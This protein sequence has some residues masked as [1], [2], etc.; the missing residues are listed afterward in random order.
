[1]VRVHQVY[2]NI[3]QYSENQKASISFS[4]FPGIGPARFQLLISY[5]GNAQNAWEAPDKTLAQVGFPSQLLNSFLFFRKT[6]NREEYFNKLKKQHII[7]V[8]FGD[9][10]YPSGLAQ[11]SDPPI[12]LYVNVKKGTEKIDL[13]K[14]IGVVGTRQV[15][16]YGRSVTESL[17]KAL[18][19]YGFTI[20]SGMALGVDAIAHCS[21]LENGGKTIAVLGCGVDIVAPSS[22]RNIYDSILSTG[23]GAIISEMPLGHMPSKGLFP[24]RNRIISGLSLGV[25]V[26][27]GAEDSGALITA[28]FAAD[29]G[30][31][32]FAVPG[33]I[34]SVFSKGPSKLLKNGATLVETAEDVLDALG[35]TPVYKSKI[36]KI[37]QNTIEQALL[38]LLGMQPMDIDE[39]VK[40]TQIPMAQ[41][42]TTLTVLELRGI[43]KAVGNRI[44]EM[45]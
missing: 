28:K 11:I 15:T 43:I 30:R 13:S 22:N 21:A 12:V 3:V 26:T 9:E 34:T 5:F 23:Q 24:A 42:A 25:I 29:Q 19:S 14:T 45:I 6:F 1:M 27:E 17:V 16:S 44:F 32:V 2:A 35:I 38:D 37:G 31:E 41:V 39:L 4:V 20:V 40:K 33:P 10:R 7:P 18:V 8:A 36:K